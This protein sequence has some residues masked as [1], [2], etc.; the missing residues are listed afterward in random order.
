MVSLRPA[1]PHDAAHLQYS[2]AC[3]LSPAALGEAAQFIFAAVIG[4]VSGHDSDQEVRDSAL[5]VLGSLVAHC[6]DILLTDPA[7]ADQVFSLLLKRIENEVTR[8]AAMRAL[9][10]VASSQNSRSFAASSAIVSHATFASVTRLLGQQDRSLKQTALRL[11]NAL[12]CMHP[13]RV[14]SLSPAQVPLFADLLNELIALMSEAD[15]FICNL[16]INVAHNLVLRSGGAKAVGCLEGCPDCC[17]N[18]L[19]VL[20]LGP[21]CAVGPRRRPNVI[22]TAAG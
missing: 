1:L 7:R 13:E 4:H 10:K 20:M 12:V 5:V 6:G 8:M 3:S 17:T 15:L 14:E 9:I 18:V 16:A 2:S 19:F 11:L 22:S 21:F